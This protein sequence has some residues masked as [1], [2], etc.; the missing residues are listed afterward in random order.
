MKLP[1]TYFENLSTSKYKAYLKLLPNMKKDST[2]AITMII[3]TLLA[4]S[5]LGFFAINPTLST[6]AN[7]HKQLAD[8]RFVYEQLTTKIDNMTSL[9]QQHEDLSEDLPVVFDAVPKDPSVVRL[10]G[11]IEALAE[12]K[13]V[14]INSFKVSKVQLSKIEQTEKEAPSFSFVIGAEG[15][16]DSMMN[17][18]SSLTEFDRIVT[19]ELASL[20]KDT[21]RDVLLM[22]ITGRGYFKQ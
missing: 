22:S 9:R 6:I 10:I 7:L 1:R 16:Y 2:K 3:F 18:A 19:V 12:E 13:N 14:Q 4:S 20:V 15:S 11:Q 17:F 21:R 5:I 8:S